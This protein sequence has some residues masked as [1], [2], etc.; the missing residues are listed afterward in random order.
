[1]ESI[2]VFSHKQI[3]QTVF[4]Y[5]MQLQYATAWEARSNCDAATNT[6]IKYIRFVRL[7]SALAATAAA[8]ELC[9]SQIVCGAHIA[10]GY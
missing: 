5:F 2:A 6:K 3:S 9:A 10:S 4:V 7:A 8:V 1:M